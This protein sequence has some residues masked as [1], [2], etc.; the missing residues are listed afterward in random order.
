MRR[1]FEKTL[2]NNHPVIKKAIA[3][4]EMDLL[5]NMLSLITKSNMVQRRNLLSLFKGCGF[6]WKELNEMT[7]QIISRQNEETKES[8]RNFPS[9]KVYNEVMKS[10][11]EV[12]GYEKYTRER[13]IIS[14]QSLYETISLFFSLNSHPST[15]TNKNLEDLYILHF[16]NEASL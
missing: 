14:K 9:Q 2:K 10:D 3:K 16:T 8:M 15:F 7:Q 11:V 13:F 6:T 5:S 4:K 12:F 1:L